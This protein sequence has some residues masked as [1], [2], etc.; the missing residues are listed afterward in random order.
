M[1]GANSPPKPIDPFF[2]LIHNGE[3]NACVGIQ[4]SDENYVDGYMEAARELVVAANAGGGSDN[5]SVIAVFVD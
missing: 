2:E 1:S 5:I 3:W 4:G